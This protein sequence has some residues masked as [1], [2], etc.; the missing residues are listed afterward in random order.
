MVSEKGKGLDLETEPPLPPN[1]VEF[2]PGGGLTHIL[3]RFVFV[4]LAQRN[5]VETARLTPALRK[6]VMIAKRA[7]RG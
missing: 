3:S 6:C 5:Q 7:K 2:L 1:F 4:S